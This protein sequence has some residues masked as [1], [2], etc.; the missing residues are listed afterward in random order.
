M[1]TSRWSFKTS[2]TTTRANGTGTEADERTLFNLGVAF[3][4]VALGCSFW[5]CL[6]LVIE[7]T[8]KGPQTWTLTVFTLP[9]M[10]YGVGSVWVEIVA[11]K[12]AKELRQARLGLDVD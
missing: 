2:T 10:W 6:G 12:R 4:L 9:A 3:V 7:L 8:H 5:S 11:F 1:D